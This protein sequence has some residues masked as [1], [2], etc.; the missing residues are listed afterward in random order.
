MPD[1]VP[2]DSVSVLVRPGLQTEELDDRARARRISAVI[3]H[4]EKR[5]R[6]RFPILAYENL[7]GTL[8]FAAA[9]AGFIVSSVLFLRGV[10]PV[11][12]CVVA[13]A[14]CASILH[15]LEHDLIHNIYFRHSP[16]V[17]NGMMFCVWMFRGNIINPWHR[18]KLHLLHHKDSGQ[19]TD[20]EERLIGNGLSYGLV[21]WL[22]T[23]D[24]FI[25]TLVRSRELG[26]IPAFNFPQMLRASAPF[27]PLYCTL[28]YSWLLY[29]V[30][31]TLVALCGGE[32]AWPGWINTGMSVID[33][34]VVIYVLPN[35]LRQASINLI[36]S[37]MHY[38]GDIDGVVDQTQV[39]NRWY[40]WPLQAFCFN[41]GSTH[42]IH[43]F[44]VQQPFYLRQMIVAPAHAAMRKYGVR[45]NDMGTISR[46]NRLNPVP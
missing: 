6:R 35:M 34:L 41:F 44:V 31:T 32:L 15:E 12:A 25:A 23:F 27:V 11:W 13:N 17:Q 2:L 14:F 19:H 46:A 37:S 16:L 20:L 33:L 30:P 10:I 40:L 1:S 3:R 45:F 36:S 28:L 26:S 18:R 9:S 4:S 39:L 29:H 7:L 21:R 42:G 22:A 24:G 8:L 5:L 43:H 38:Y